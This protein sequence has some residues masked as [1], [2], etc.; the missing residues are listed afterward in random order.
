MGKS[1]PAREVADN[2]EVINGIGPVF[3]RRLH[4][5]GIHTFADLVAASPERLL[6]IVQAAPGLADP[7]SWREQAGQLVKNR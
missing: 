3:A 4:A 5:A 7:D 6:E 1:A 2:L